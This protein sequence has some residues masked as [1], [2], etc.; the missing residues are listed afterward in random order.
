MDL[1]ESTMPTI[2]CGGA[3]L[4][5]RDSNMCGRL[6]KLVEVPNG[7]YPQCD[8][9]YEYVFN[10]HNR[11]FHECVSIWILPHKGKY[12]QILNV[13][14][15]NKVEAFKIKSKIYGPLHE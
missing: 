15:V 8:H 13:L 5:N 12:L 3:P 9:I 6:G 14:L 11:G 1:E 7:L 2:G 4:S 10:Y